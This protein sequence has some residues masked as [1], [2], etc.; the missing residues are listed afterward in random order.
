MS[1]IIVSYWFIINPLKYI[2]RP[3]KFTRDE[4]LEKEI[5]LEGYPFK[6]YFTNIIVN[7]AF[8]TGILP[9]YKIIIVGNNLKEKLSKIELK[10]VIYH[11]IGHHKNKH[12]LKLFFVN[13]IVQTFAFLLFSE[14]NKIHHTYTFMEPLSVALT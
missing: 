10:A 8:A 9:F 3:K 13:V 2:F 5:K 11:E 7:N 1:S 14:V 6:I 12:I 4:A